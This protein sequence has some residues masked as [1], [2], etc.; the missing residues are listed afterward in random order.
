MEI[1]M[2]RKTAIWAAAIAALAC[3]S[4]LRA[5]HSIS[6]FEISAPIW[7]EGTVVRYEPKDPHMM[8]A[9]EE[10]SEDGQV[11][12]WTV[13]GPIPARLYRMALAPGFLKAGDVIDVCGFALKEKFLRPSADADDSPPRF[14]H[15]HVLVLPD[16]HMQSWGPYGKLDNCIRLDDQTHSWVDFLNADRLARDLW[17]AGQKYADAASVASKT[18]VDEINRSI[19]KPC[20]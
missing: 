7:V 11:Q 8:I 4:P 3:A 16:G 13:E 6:M 18:L 10:K 5:H 19:T 12:Q 9:L 1:A 20:G 15:G 17:C 2:N 14:V